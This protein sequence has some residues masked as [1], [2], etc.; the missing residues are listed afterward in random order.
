[1]KK[2]A[3]RQIAPGVMANVSPDARPETISALRVAARLARKRRLPY[4]PA[5]DLADMREAGVLQ[6]PR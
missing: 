4:I 3:H 5:S 1:M 2:H 6:P